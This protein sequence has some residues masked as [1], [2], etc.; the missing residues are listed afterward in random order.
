[1][2][3]ATFRIIRKLSRLSRHTS[4]SSRLFLDY[5]GTFSRLSGHFLDC[6]ETS[7][8]IRTLCISSGYFVLQSIRK[9]FSQLMNLSQKLSG[10][11]KTFRSAL[12]T[13]WRGFCDSETIYVNFLWGEKEPYIEMK[14]H[15]IKGLYTRSTWEES[16]PSTS[17][18]PSGD[19]HKY[20][21]FLFSYAFASP[22][23]FLPWFQGSAM[24][25]SQRVTFP[26]L[27]SVGLET[28]KNVF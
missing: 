1:M 11:A 28:Q 17:T 15:P 7:Q 6:P 12:L 13:R 5:L 26:I 25:F 19:H 3:I 2:Q 4:R 10:F 20:S 22:Y 14:V 23:N 21:P 16:S 18:P 27:L 9:F 24:F 8:F